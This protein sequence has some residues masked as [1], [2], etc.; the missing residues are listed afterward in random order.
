MDS[1]LDNITKLLSIHCLN[2][3]V[4]KCKF[5]L[6]HYFSLNTKIFIKKIRANLDYDIEQNSQ[7]LQYVVHKDTLFAAHTY[8]LFSENKQQQYGAS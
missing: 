3:F 1:K 7:I 2:L 4:Q 6:L 5:T 8:G